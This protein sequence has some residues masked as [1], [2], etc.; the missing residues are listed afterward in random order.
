MGN[1]PIISTDRDAWNK[2]TEYDLITVGETVYSDT[3]SRW[4]S[5][6]LIPTYH[7]V[8]GKHFKDP[9]SWDQA[10]GLSWY[11]DTRI[12]MAVDIFATVVSSLFPVVSIVALYCV[13]RMSV[14]LG[15]IAAFTAFFSLCLALMTRASRVEIFASTTALVMLTSD[16]WLRR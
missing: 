10:S 8:F 13:H 4:V 3:F 6:S 5:E 1:F 16:L 12:K 11:S 7:S 15:I 9:V 2:E 14:R